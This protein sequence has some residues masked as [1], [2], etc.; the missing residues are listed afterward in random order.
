MWH[1]IPLEK[2]V[3][4]SEAYVKILSLNAANRTLSISLPIHVSLSYHGF[5]PSS[6]LSYGRGSGNEPSLVL[7][8]A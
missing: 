6:N 3:V 1:S 5:Q 7:V 8:E 4:Q 2:V